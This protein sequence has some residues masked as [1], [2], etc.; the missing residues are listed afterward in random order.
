MLERRRE[1]GRRRGRDATDVAS[2]H[3]G[4]T[5]GEA[6]RNAVAIGELEEQTQRGRVLSR[7]KIGDG[8]FDCQLTVRPRGRKRG[9]AANEPLHCQTVGPFDCAE[10]GA[11][12]RDHRLVKQP[13][14]IARV[15][16]GERSIEADSKRI[17]GVRSDQA[18]VAIEQREGSG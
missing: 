5:R 11:T 2:E 13:T 7:G 14:C 9:E 6:D 17:L 16:R 3:T 12:D 18:R 15:P 10:L 8:N 1:R 4:T